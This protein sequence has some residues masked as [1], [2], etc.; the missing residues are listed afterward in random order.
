MCQ[1]RQQQ[2]K[3][4]LTS[5]SQILAFDGQKTKSKNEFRR[6]RKKL[7]PPTILIMTLMFILFM[8]AKELLNNQSLHFLEFFIWRVLGAVSIFH[9]DINASKVFFSKI[10]TLLR[11]VVQTL[12]CKGVKIKRYFSQR[13]CEIYN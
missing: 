3:D 2:Y 5:F 13:C 12:H 8:E 10:Q 4:L 1:A 6:L 7:S 9:F 11:I